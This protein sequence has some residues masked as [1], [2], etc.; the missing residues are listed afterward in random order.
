MA[1]TTILRRL[2]FEGNLDD[3]PAP[4]PHFESSR[5]PPNE[6]ED[7]PA[8]DSAGLDSNA[9][10]QRARLEMVIASA[11]R[12][13]KGLPPLTTEDS[14]L[15]GTHRGSISSAV[16]AVRPPWAKA[17]EATVTY[18]AEEL[19]LIKRVQHTARKLLC[20]RS[21]MAGRKAVVAM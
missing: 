9:N 6:S 16:M 2:S 18:T 1:T 20:K 5:S 13:A 15:G 10:W 7:A 4:T 12:A 21:S 19:R 14:P 8:I 17:E 3:E 11:Q